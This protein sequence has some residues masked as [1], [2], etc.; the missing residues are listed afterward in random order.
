[1]LYQILMESVNNPTVA[2]VISWVPGDDY[3]FEIKDS[4]Q[5]AHAYFQ[6]EEMNQLHDLWMSNGFV[7]H[8]KSVW[9]HQ[10]DNFRLGRPD[11]LE[12][13]PAPATN[14]EGASCAAEKGKE[15]LEHEKIEELVCR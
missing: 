11:L 5:L 3:L 10:S 12:E 7:A 2:E 15:L 1:M 14:G 13:I 6:I 8:G 4:V 9:R